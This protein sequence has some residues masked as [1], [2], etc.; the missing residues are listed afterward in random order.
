ML[1]VCPPVLARPLDRQ[2]AYTRRHR[3]KKMYVRRAG[4]GSL[5]PAR[6]DGL[7]GCTIGAD[8]TGPR[9]SRSQGT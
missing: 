6:R 8:G 1:T 4:G 7:D 5:Q 2:P 9:S 3:E